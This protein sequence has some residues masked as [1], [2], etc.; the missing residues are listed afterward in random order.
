MFDLT[1]DRFNY[2]D[3][4]RNVKM[5]KRLTQ[6][7]G[8]D[9]EFFCVSLRDLGWRETIQFSTTSHTDVLK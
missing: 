1:K 8:I 7:D 3:L 2:Y 9:I 5:P 4:S 6:D